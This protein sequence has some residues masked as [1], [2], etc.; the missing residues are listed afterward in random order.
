MAKRTATRTA[1]AM[2]TGAILALGAISG[3]YLVSPRRTVEAMADAAT[4]GRSDILVQY[5]DMP[6]LRADM[7]RRAAHAIAQGYP[8]GRVVLN[9]KIVV[10][11]LAGPQIDRMFSNDGTRRAVERSK[12][13][14]L[15]MAVTFSILR[16]GADHFTARLDRPHPVDLL[17]TRRGTSWRLTG[18]RPRATRTPRAEEIA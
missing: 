9:P 12:R 3:W 10:E 7:R 17:F 14:H 11:A 4:H 18:I 16:G 5:M 15:D 13:S 6:A 2:G 8:P 1:V